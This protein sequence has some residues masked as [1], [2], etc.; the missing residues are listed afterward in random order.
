MAH[1]IISIHS[2]NI[3]DEQQGAL[4]LWQLLSCSFQRI[5]LK[6]IIVSERRRQEKWQNQG[7][8]KQKLKTLDLTNNP[9]SELLQIEKCSLWRMAPSQLE[10]H[11]HW[12]WPLRSNHLEDDYCNVGEFDMGAFLEVNTD[13]DRML[14]NVEMDDGAMEANSVTGTHSISK[15]HGL[16]VDFNSPKITI[17]FQACSKVTIQPQNM[18]GKM[19]WR[20]CEQRRRRKPVDRILQIA[21]MLIQD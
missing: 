7:S 17:I 20:G 3:L 6:K 2:P 21:R 16:A 1:W 9:Q 10:C 12:I 4:K 11:L 5:I 14:I 19:V 13:G 8:E 18:E 15:E